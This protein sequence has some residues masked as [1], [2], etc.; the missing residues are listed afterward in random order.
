MKL[1]RNL[2]EGFTLIEI[3]LSISVITIAGLS[4]YSLASIVNTGFKAEKEYK[5]ILHVMNFID[6]TYAVINDYNL[7][8]SKKIKEI[9][10]SSKT[11]TSTSFDN[12]MQSESQPDI[13]FNA[14]SGTIEVEQ[15]S[16]YINPITSFPH[17]GYKITTSLIPGRA[18]T[19]LATQL[20]N[21][22]NEIR[23]NSTLVKS[24]NKKIDVESTSLACNNDF[25]S[26][27]I[28]KWP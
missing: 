9:S 20:S 5:N 11:F 26:I 18:C 17:R 23:I 19:K 2:N 21:Q 14:F 27:E 16:D 15:A 22:A 25:N 13:L 7:I 3:L 6:S 4:L 24:L 12:E 8:S 28:T 10:R 1:K